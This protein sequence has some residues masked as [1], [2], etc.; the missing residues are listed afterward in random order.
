M[1]MQILHP[2]PSSNGGI[3]IPQLYEEIDQIELGSKSIGKLKT[4][5][6]SSK[7]FLQENNDNDMH[8]RLKISL[9]NLLPKVLQIQDIDTKLKNKLTK[10]INFLIGYDLNFT[11][12]FRHH[13]VQNLKDGNYKECNLDHNNYIK[14]FDIRGPYAAIMFPDHTINLYDLNTQKMIWSRN[15]GL[16]GT[17]AEIKIAGDYVLVH[18]VDTLNENFDSSDENELRMK[19]MDIKNG[20][21]ENSIKLDT[22]QTL[23][24]GDRIFC[25]RLDGK[26]DV[27]AINGKPFEP[28]QLKNSE[29]HIPTFVGSERFLVLYDEDILHIY[30]RD[31]NE[32]KLKALGDMKASCIHIDGSRLFFEGAKE[33]T[34]KFCGI[35]LE[36]PDVLNIDTN[37]DKLEISK[38]MTHEG[39]VFVGFLSGVVAFFDKAEQKFYPLCK[40][41]NGIIDLVIDGKVLYSA[42]NTGW[43]TM[44]KVNASDL[45]TSE[46]I[47]T[48]S[49]PPRTKY[50][51]GSEKIHCASENTFTEYDY[52]IPP[53]EKS[54]S[55]DGEMLVC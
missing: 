2:Q 14:R 52:C 19:I 32:V 23:I 13:F 53:K 35:D 30:D 47:A 39:R 4:F 17:F 33:G 21:I 55:N 38:I 11:D 20:N 22:D 27:W 44:I 12:D 51:F 45:D 1:S 28:I 37:L 48:M 40:H 18:N 5:L 3:G 10:K 54:Q 16:K 8:E 24:I 6:R 36:T 42:S 29:I 7:L 46:I 26:V 31:K 34:F 49:L 43:D 41:P 25:L 15:P 50:S 9:K